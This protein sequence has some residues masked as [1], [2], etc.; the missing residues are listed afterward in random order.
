MET[1]SCEQARTL[2]DKK[3]DGNIDQSE[4]ARLGA[5]LAECE[6]CR[7]EYKALERTHVYLSSFA[8]EVPS[9]LSANVME[10]IQKEPK[11]SATILRRLRP[12]IALPVAAL[13]CVALLHSP[14]F[15]V[16]MPAKEVADMAEEA[17]KVNGDLNASLSGQNEKPKYDDLADGG[18]ED[19]DPEEVAPSYA[20]NAITGTLLTL[21]FTDERN[22]VLVNKENGQCEAV[23]YSQNENIITIEKDGKKADLVLA[24][25]TLT[26]TDKPTLDALLSP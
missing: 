17:N 15:D 20:S 13:L 14:L 18:L 21:R 4:E 25:D 24:G 19:A 11:R 8:V 12:L 2:F 5:H 16:M 1:M 9:E 10:R 6:A 23:L 7:R 22:A 3:I 26:P